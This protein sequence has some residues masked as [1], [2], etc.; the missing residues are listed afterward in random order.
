MTLTIQINTYMSVGKRATVSVIENIP[1]GKD[2]I[3]LN[4]S[5]VEVKAAIEAVNSA[6]KAA[7]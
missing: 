7:L 4:L 3:V 2:S 6:L 1:N 5:G